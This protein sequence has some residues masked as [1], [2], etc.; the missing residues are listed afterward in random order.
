MELSQPTY[1]KNGVGKILINKAPDGT[2]S[3]NLADTVM[4]RFSKDSH[5]AMIMTSEHVAAFSAA[6]A[7]ARRR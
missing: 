3:P 5:R 2:R 7:K 6:F 1:S 4:I